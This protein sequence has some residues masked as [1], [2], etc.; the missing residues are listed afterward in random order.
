MWH[1]KARYKAK[2]TEVCVDHLMNTHSQSPDGSVI[3][4]TLLSSS[5][6]STPMKPITIEGLSVEPYLLTRA[7]SETPVTS[8]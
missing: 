4:R 6:K 5:V 2:S 7:N 3:E 1:D 8:R